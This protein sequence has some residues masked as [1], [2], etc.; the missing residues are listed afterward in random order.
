MLMI[1]NIIFIK[2]WNDKKMEDVKIF[3]V[4]KCTKC[5]FKKLQKMWDELYSTPGF[6]REDYKGLEARIVKVIEDFKE[7]FETNKETKNGK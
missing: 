1:W 5:D 2:I 7:D 3:K 6:T 4:A